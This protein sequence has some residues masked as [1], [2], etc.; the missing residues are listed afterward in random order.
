MPFSSPEHEEEE[1]QEEE[2]CEQAEASPPAKTKNGGVD[3]VE[4]EDLTDEPVTPGVVCRTFS[5][6]P[7][8]VQTGQAPRA[9]VVCLVAFC[10]PFVSPTQEIYRMSPRRRQPRDP[11][12]TESNANGHATV[13]KKP[14]NGHAVEG[15]RRKRQRWQRYK[16]QVRGHV[17]GEGSP[18]ARRSSSSGSSWRASRRLT[19]RRSASLGQSSR[20]PRPLRSMPSRSTRRLWDG[21]PTSRKP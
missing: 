19:P 12:E 9:Y 8:K 11:G 3:G 15:R 1:Q 4:N 21:W 16:C 6:T 5:S 20:R 18:P 14:T 13:S 2:E 7:P 17:A 10:A